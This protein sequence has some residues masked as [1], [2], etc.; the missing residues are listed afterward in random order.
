MNSSAQSLRRPWKRTPLGIEAP[1]RFLLA[2]FAATAALA[3][4][5][6]WMFWAT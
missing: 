3:S 4:L 1:T 5:I 6:F 2:I